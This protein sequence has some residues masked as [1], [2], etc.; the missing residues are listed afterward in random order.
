MK[1][2]TIT[3]E[4][5]CL[6]VTDGAHNSPNEVS[7]GYPMASSKDMRENDFDMSA[8]KQISEH[9]YLKLVKGNCKPLLGDVLI[10]KDGNS[11]LKYIFA[12]KE[13]REMVLLSSIA[14]LRPNQEKI[15]PSYLQYIL[16][17]PDT[18]KDMENYVSG[19]AIPR[20]VLKDFKSMKIPLP[21]IPTQKK[22]ASILSAYD[23]LIE[24]N[25]K[26]IKLLE[27]AAQNIYKEWFVNFRFPGWENT[28]F[29]EETGLPEGWR[30]GLMDEIMDVVGGGT[31]STEIPEYW[32]PQEVIW[33]SPTDL[34]R[35]NSIVLIDSSKKISNLG[36]KKSSSKLLPPKTILMSSRATIGLFGLINEPCCTNQGFINIIPNTEIF[37]YYILYNLFSR[38]KEIEANATGA[39]FKEISKKN[40]K[41][42][43][44]LIPP[45]EYV[46]KYYSLID[47]IIA[48]IENFEKQNQKLKEARDIL[49]PRLMNQTIEV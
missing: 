36:L 17:S 7:E 39:T 47:N 1:W 24:N 11:Y 40:F 22:I 3:I 48:Q 18:K 19:A 49:L 15:I 31:P 10:I 21:P 38:K 44:I 43:P 45:N 35:N 4:K 5:T 2:E 29:D 41:S 9:D 34:S 16:R 14:I 37:R 32:D 8:V 42:L 23:D 20:I 33:F 28:R 6:L 25:L 12:I 46:G 30:A 26:R 13:E 27:E